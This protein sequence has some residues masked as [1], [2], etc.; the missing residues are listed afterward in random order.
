MIVE[1]DGYIKCIIV[2]W[3]QGPISLFSGI[4]GIQLPVEGRWLWDSALVAGSLDHHRREY[5]LAVWDRATCVL[6]RR[7]LTVVQERSS[8]ATM[9]LKNA[10]APNDIDII[11]SLLFESYRMYRSSCP[12]SPARKKFHRIFITGLERSCSW[13]SSM[14]MR[15]DHWAGIC[16][17]YWPSFPNS[18]QGNPCMQSSISEC[19]SDKTR[20]FVRS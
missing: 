5:I 12:R 13:G 19:S 8:I 10:F 16:P 9:V 11:N 2:A 14:L 15:R 18:Y 1:L 20:S 3:R 4:V 6:K 17:V 7:R